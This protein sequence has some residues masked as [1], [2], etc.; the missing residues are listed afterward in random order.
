MIC[1]FPSRKIFVVGVTG[2]K[3]KTTTTELIAAIFEAAGR[4]TAVL[5]SYRM[6]MNGDADLNRSGMSMPGRGAIQ[7]FLRQ[8]A[9]GGCELAVLEVT[10]QG[11]LQHRHRFIRFGAAVFI[12]IHPEHIEA[13]GSFE[14]YR[15]AKLDFFRRAGK[16]SV[17]VVNGDDGNSFLFQKAAGGGRAV[18]FSKN[19]LRGFAL[20]DFLQSDFNRENAA[21]AAAFARSRGIEEEII[22]KTLA[23]FSGVPGRLEYVQKEPFSV[24]V[25]YAHTPDSL[26]AVYKTLRERHLSGG[27]GLICVLGAAG[28]GRDKWKRPEMGKIA[29]ENC[30]EII[31]TDEDPYDEDSGRILAEIKSGIQNASFPIQNAREIINREEA[32]EKAVGL[33]K[34]GDVVVITGKGSEPW[35]HLEKKRKIPWSDREAVLKALESKKNNRD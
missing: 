3:G 1:G 31:L 12:N 5:N 20:S 13:H 28:G 16:G 10:S 18:L 15:E 24:V 21:A 26:A 22:R 9:R 4:K 17:F 35:M 2:T 33:A 25:D 7:R 30:D 23:D 29:A 32:I 11:V 6:K 27:G 14:K 8:A 34:A 19:D